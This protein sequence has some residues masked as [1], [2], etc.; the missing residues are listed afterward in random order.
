VRK[1][2]RYSND[3]DAVLCANFIHPIESVLR[4]C[5]QDEAHWPVF[6][7]S[8]RVRNFNKPH[9]PSLKGTIVLKMRVLSVLLHDA[10]VVVLLFNYGIDAI[11]LSLPDH[12]DEKHFTCSRS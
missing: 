11:G 2:R 12:L 10:R 5:V 6:A 7:I 8:T 9:K 3:L 4:G 1:T